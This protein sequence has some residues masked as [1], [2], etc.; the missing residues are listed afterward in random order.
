MSNHGLLFPPDLC[1]AL[2]LYPIVFLL[3]SF[4]GFTLGIHLGTF[5]LYS[6]YSSPNLFTKPGSSDNTK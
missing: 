1:V 3:L 4:Q 6:R 5:R 2:G